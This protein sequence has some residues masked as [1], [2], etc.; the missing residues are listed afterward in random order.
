MQALFLLEVYYFF[1]RNKKLNPGKRVI[2]QNI[3][4]LWDIQLVIP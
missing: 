3:F 1:M 2:Y 4:K